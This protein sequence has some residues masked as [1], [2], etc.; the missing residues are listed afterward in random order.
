MADQ[1]GFTMII[2]SGTLDLAFRGF[3]TV[4]SDAFDATETHYDKI[5]MTVPSV[6][7]DETYGWIGQ[8]PQLREWVGPRQVK[9]LSAHG[10]TIVNRIFESSVSV[11]RTD[12]ED[13]RLGIFKPMF[14]EMGTFARR[15]PEELVFGLLKD[16]FAAPS[17]D[18][19]T[20]F[21]EDHVLEKDGV[22]SS[23]SNVQTGSGDAWF[24]LDTSR[25]V[26]PIIWQ[27]RMPYEFQ[28]LTETNDPH[29]FLNDQYLYGVRARV[30]AGFG[31][32]QLAFGSKATLNAAN[33]AAARAAMMDFRADGGRILGVKPTVLVVPPSLEEEAL[34]L[35]NAMVND[36]GGSNVWSKTA[37]LI[38]TPYVKA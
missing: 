19:T 31:L 11:K 7:R 24:L 35:L 8:F 32:W 4:Y 34:Q 18:G 1:E 10:F 21:A 13:D 5:A 2:N 20:F 9:N 29:V 12:I 14:A 17:F 27:E 25:A 28:S 30:N 16:G 6:S 3:K 22:K 33:Y 36:G 37:E 23:V 26:R 15:H 38:V